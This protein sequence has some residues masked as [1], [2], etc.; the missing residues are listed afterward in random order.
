MDDDIL[1]WTR[2]ELLADVVRL[3]TGIRAHH[4][5]GGTNCAGIGHY[6]N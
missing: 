5:S 1:N 2:D 6:R 4:D 3:R